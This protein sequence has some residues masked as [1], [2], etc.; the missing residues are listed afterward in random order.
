MLS[1]PCSRF[2]THEIFR[3][4]IHKPWQ[5]NAMLLFILILPKIHLFCCFTSMVFLWQLYHKNLDVYQN[6]SRN[7]VQ[8]K[9]T[10]SIHQPSLSSF[11][12][13]PW[14]LWLCSKCRCKERSLDQSKDTPTNSQDSTNSSANRLSHKRWN[15]QPAVLHVFVSHSFHYQG[16]PEWH[17]DSNCDVLLLPSDGLML[18]RAANAIPSLATAAASLLWRTCAGWFVLSVFG[19]SKVFEDTFISCSTSCS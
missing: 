2:L 16:I 7:E 9:I 4:R 6:F 13:W 10:F 1:G 12:R 15:A 19:T 14:W 17:S 11:Q 5:F 8:Q 18:P 3:S